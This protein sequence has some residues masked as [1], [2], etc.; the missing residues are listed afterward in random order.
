VFAFKSFTEAKLCISVVYYAAVFFYFCSHGRCLACR[1]VFQSSS[2]YLFY[3][4]LSWN[5]RFF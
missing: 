1:F 2:V 3:F 4:I 5:K